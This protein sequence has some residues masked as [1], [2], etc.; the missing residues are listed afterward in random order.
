MLQE[1]HGG[2]ILSFRYYWCDPKLKYGV[3]MYPM[4]YHCQIWKERNRERR[5]ETKL[6]GR[7]QQERKERAIKVMDKNRQDRNKE[8]HK[9]GKEGREQRVT[10][11]KSYRKDAMNKRRKEDKQNCVSLSF[12]YPLQMCLFQLLYAVFFWD[13]F[14]SPLGFFFISAAQF[15][16]F[17]SFLWDLSFWCGC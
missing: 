5:K 9:E 6:E 10:G 8:G 1:E 2:F 12:C 17:I 7:R 14:Q 11:G 4:H 3:F 15:V 16:F 13:A